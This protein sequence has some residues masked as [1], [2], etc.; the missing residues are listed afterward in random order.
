MEQDFV[1]GTLQ[2][3]L[4]RGLAVCTAGVLYYTQQKIDFLNIRGHHGRFC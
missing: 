3:S 2:A 4:R 1:L